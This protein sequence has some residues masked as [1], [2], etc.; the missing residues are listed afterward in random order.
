MVVVTGQQ[1]GLFT[2]PLYTIYKAL[3]VV[4]LARRL[5]D[6]HP[7]RFL[8]LFWMASDDHD[9]AEV[10]HAVV[11]DRGNRL[12]DLRHP[13]A[14][15]PGGPVG[16][17][18]LGPKI[19]TLLAQ[20]D[21]V[22]PESEFKPRV[23]EWARG[24]YRPTATLCEA[25]ARAMLALFAED[26]LV[27]VDPMEPELRR[28]A[29]PIF[30][31]ELEADPPSAELLTQ[32]N[33][34]LAARG[35]QAQIH[36]QPEMVN[37]FVLLDGLR[38]ALV[39]DG[40]GYR[41]KSG[42][43]GFSSAELLELLRRSPERFSPNAALRPIVQDHIFP[44]AAY[45]AGPAE[46]AYYAQLSGLYELFGVPMPVIYPRASLTLVEARVTELLRKF[47]LRLED[48]FVDQARLATQ[49]VGDQL[50]EELEGLLEGCR[51]QIGD[52]F[53]AL[54]EKAVV[55]EPTLRDYLQSAAGKVEHQLEGV[56]HKLRQAQRAREKASRGQI[57]RISGHLFPDGQ[58]QERVVNII[59]FLVR[60][61]L[62]FIAELKGTDLEPWEHM[63]MEIG[64]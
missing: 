22:L 21:E 33:R 48:V 30:R 46:I 45:V 17:F 59:P 49:V 44:V 32:R 7:F 62:G 40:G 39:R 58:L 53:Q 61:G 60:H 20:L 56:G 36:A 35:Y 12:K 4:Q 16:P 55:F 19:E 37:V 14:H 27:L 15:P 26:G 51:R 10:N 18:R 29:E 25:F 38:A 57:A 42:D 1:V 34:E 3:T 50:P 9:F 23:M 2:G 31:A 64:R 52:A 5:E 28:L 11:F 13:D 43:R 6:R 63:A 47:K 8:P 24:A 54:L 41:L